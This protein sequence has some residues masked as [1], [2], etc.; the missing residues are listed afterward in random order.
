[1][2]KYIVRRTLGLIPLLIGIVLLSFILMKMAPG[3]P[4]AQFNQNNRVT[5]EQIDRW[6]KRWCLERNAGPLG[7][8][9]EFGGWVGIW[10]CDTESFISQQGG[11]NFLPPQLGG[12]DNGLIHGD[13]GF[14]IDQGRPVVDMIAERIPA[15]LLLTIAA[16]VLRVS[17]AILLGVIAAVRRYS[18][19]D[20]VVTFF[21]YVFYSLPTFWL[22][23]MFIFLFAV[24]FRVLPPQGITTPRAW[25]PF[26]TERY[27]GEFGEKPLEAIVDIARHL[28]LPV[29]VLVLVNIAADSRFVRASMLDAL[30]QDFVRTA[31]AKGLPGRTVVMKHAFRNAMLPV[32]TNVALE[33]PFLFG[34][35]VVTETIFSWPGM[36]LL[37][38]TG[39]G[40]RDYFLL[41]GLLLI[42]SMLI[43]FFNLLADVLYAVVDPRIRYD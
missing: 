30:S 9:R 3:G 24:A 14:S 4:Q 13:L 15:T 36:G 22:G 39:V 28:I 26:G 20:Q 10:N 42:T 17:V 25:P 23:L 29:T 40:N 18:I 7:I 38:I 41:M 8:A 6:L 5:E 21:S 2:A 43:L 33:L 11:L 27:W 32:V 37:F 35:A 1:M 34:G 12:G 16:L 31:R 19:F